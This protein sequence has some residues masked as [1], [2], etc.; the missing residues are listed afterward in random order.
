MADDGNSVCFGQRAFLNLLA[1]G[2]KLSDVFRT[3]LSLRVLQDLDARPRTL[4]EISDRAGVLPGRL[5]KF[6]E[7]LESAGVVWHTTPGDDGSLTYHMVPG[8]TEAVL[9]VFGPGSQHEDRDQ[10][11]WRHLQ[12]RL[13]AVLRGEVSYAPEQFSWPPCDASGLAAFEQSMAVGMRLMAK[14]FVVHAEQ[15]WPRPG[16]LLDVGGGDGTLARTLIEHRPGLYVD[17]LNVPA[18][19]PLVEATRQ[20]CVDKDRLGFVGGDFLAE[21]LPDGYDSLSLVRVLH[22]WPPPEAR[23]LVRKAYRALPPGGLLL[24]CEE[25]RNRDRL[26]DQLFWSYFLMGTDDCTSRLYSIGH[27][28]A[29]LGAEGFEHFRVWPG[30]FEI[31]SARK[32]DAHGSPPLLA[33]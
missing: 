25:F 9:A 7:C 29:L 2:E 4:D 16:R 5:H 19:A 17:V 32:P 10:Y 20:T 23:E 26:A 28:R 18:A 33:V 11:P 15:I 14:S 27:Y 6:M 21:E 13:E 22:D 12:G 24:I 31:L 30:E 3:A 1:N 8:M